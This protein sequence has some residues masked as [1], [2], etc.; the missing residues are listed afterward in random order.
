MNRPPTGAAASFAATGSLKTATPKGAN[1]SPAKS[2]PPIA[3]ITGR[4]SSVISRKSIPERIDRDVFSILR[5]ACFDASSENA[6][7]IGSYAG[8]IADNAWDLARST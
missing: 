4:S 5:G 6:A 7:M 1:D 3:T 8:R 2:I